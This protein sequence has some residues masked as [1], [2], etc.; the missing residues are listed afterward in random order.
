MELDE[1]IELV[2]EQQG[3]DLSGVLTTADKID[4]PERALEKQPIDDIMERNPMAGGGMLVQPSADGSRPGYSKD[5][6]KINRDES[7]SKVVKD[8]VATSGPGTGKIF[9]DPAAIEIVK[10]NLNKI[11]KQRNN[12]ALFEWSEDSDWYRKLRK[13][14]NPNTKTGTNREYT[15]KLINQVV[16]EFFPGAYHG[17]NA[18]TNFRNDMVVKSF[19]Q[20][21]KSVGEFDGQEKFDKVLDQ[22]TYT[23]DGKRKNYRSH[24]IGSCRHSYQ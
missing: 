15:N 8:F 19:I 23:K 16:D 11:K 6:K 10:A 21:L 18:I 13:E 3:I 9:D 4:R 22:F 7:Y 14:L 20:H 1:F 24:R 12:K 17:K 5:K 2:K